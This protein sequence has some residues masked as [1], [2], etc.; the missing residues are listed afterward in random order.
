M[1]RYPGIVLIAA[2]VILIALGLLRGESAYI[3]QKAVSVCFECI[4]LA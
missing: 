1:K 2:G 4:G 3:F